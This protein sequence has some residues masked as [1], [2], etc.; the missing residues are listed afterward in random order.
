MISREEW[1]TV[2]RDLIAD[3]QKL[4][5]PPTFEEVEALSEGRLQE[6]EAERVR[7][8]LS[9]YPDLLRV[10]TEPFDLNAE[11]VL[12]EGEI[13]AGLAK[14]RERVRPEPAPPL[15]FEQP[16]RSPRVFAIAAGVIIAVAIGAIAVRQLTNEPRGEVAQVLYPDATRGGV[17]RGVPNGAPVRLSTDTD[18][19]LQPAFESRRHY[20]EYQLELLDLAS[21]PPRR[22]WLRENV[23][24][25]PDGTYPVRLATDDLEPGL[26]RLVL[27]GVGETR[28]SLA[29][30]T[31]RLAAP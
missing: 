30:Y 25:Q 29:E 4:G 13:A 23:A 3:G 26:Y 11:G 22:V 31:I 5:P 12:T 1:E 6:P 8:L 27:F 20:G 2:Y 21:E 17:H 16:R 24:R 15:P 19:T 18:Y 10:V 7:E 28:D 14:I 9:A